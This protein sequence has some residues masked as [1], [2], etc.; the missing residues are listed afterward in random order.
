MIYKA[1]YD[2]INNIFVLFQKLKYDE[3]NQLFLIFREI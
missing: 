2:I 1:Y 3:K